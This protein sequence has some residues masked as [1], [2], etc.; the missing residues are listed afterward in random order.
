MQISTQFIIC[1]HLKCTA[2][3]N[4]RTPGYSSVPYCHGPQ[5][6]LPLPFLLW[7]L[8]F[9]VK[10]VLPS[11]PSGSF[12][13]TG[14]VFP[15]YELHFQRP[16]CSLMGLQD[17]PFH[18]RAPNSLG[19]GNCSYCGSDGQNLQSL[20]CRS[21]IHHLMYALSSLPEFY[22]PP[23]HFAD[24]FSLPKSTCHIK[25]GCQ[26]ASSKPYIM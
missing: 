22:Y 8:K 9:Y 14:K 19:K 17:Q 13:P 16:Q 26:S 23:G 6:Q 10:C 7:S 18:K 25:P 24:G 4:L 15:L 3:L 5:L 21:Q 11:F 2:L 1:F 12:S 20:L